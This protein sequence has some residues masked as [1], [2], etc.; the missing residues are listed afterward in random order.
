[1]RSNKGFALLKLEIMVIVLVLITGVTLY[2]VMQDGGIVDQL[3]D[4]YLTSENVV[5]EQ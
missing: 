2:V 3:E 1:M 4:K 5:D